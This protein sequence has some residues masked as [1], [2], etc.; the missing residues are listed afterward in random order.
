MIRFEHVSFTHAGASF[1]VLR[2]VDLTIPEGD[3]VLV[4]GR[5]G[6]GKSTLLNL[7]NGLAPHFTGGTLS[8]RVEVAG[9]DTRT[10][11][12]RD[13]AGVVGTVGRGLLV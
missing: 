6:S 8:G 9:L 2:D 7:I 3:L 1:P 10:H 5:T 13:L 4:I 12:P 11:P